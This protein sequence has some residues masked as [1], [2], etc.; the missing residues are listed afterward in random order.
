MLIAADT[1]KTTTKTFAHWWL[2]RLAVETTVN[3]EVPMTITFVRGNRDENGKWEL[4]PFH[5]DQRTMSIK[6]VF[7]FAQE[8][9]ANG[10]NVP[11]ELIESILSFA[12]TVAKANN[13]ID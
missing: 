8:Q 1:P 10:N 3:L 13:V 6:D 11:A 4:S 12:A 7:V 5:E 9:A 2:L